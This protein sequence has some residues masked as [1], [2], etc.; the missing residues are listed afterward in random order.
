MYAIHRLLTCAVA[1]MMS[2]A[3]QRRQLLSTCALIYVTFI[4]RVLFGVL[5]AIGN[6]DVV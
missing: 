2:V 4:P 6:I 5:N 3:S 1:R